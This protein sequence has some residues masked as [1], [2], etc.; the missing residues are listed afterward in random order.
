M[1]LIY[2]VAIAAAALFVSALL[3]RRYKA[4][5]DYLVDSSFPKNGKSYTTEEVYRYALV[6]D[7][8]ANQQSIVAGLYRLK[9]RGLVSDSF[10]EQR[11]SIC[12]SWNIEGDLAWTP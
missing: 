6:R 7:P 2:A 11:K 4:H 10:S 1:V 9:R 12:W 5:Y 8:N 3:R